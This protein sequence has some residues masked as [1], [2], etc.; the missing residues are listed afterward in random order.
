MAL[1]TSHLWLPHI[2]GYVGD[3]HRLPLTSWGSQGAMQGT[4]SFC[5]RLFASLHGRALHFL[6]SYSL[7]LAAGTH[8]QPRPLQG[9]WQPW[10]RLQGTA[11][12]NTQTDPTAVGNQVTAT[13][14]G[15]LMK[16][17]RLPNCCWKNNAH[18]SKY[19]VSGNSSSARTSD[20]EEWGCAGAVGVSTAPEVLCSVSLLGESSKVSAPKDKGALEV[21]ILPLTPPG[22]VYF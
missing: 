7:L 2:P 1:P 11:V 12:R 5:K 15:W 20:K 4:S 18:L 21:P 3:L 13:P 19:Y 16:G 6:S 14:R 17:Q 22:K 8:S 10:F 9:L